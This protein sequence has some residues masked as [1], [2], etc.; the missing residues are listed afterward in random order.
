MSEPLVL[1]CDL[2]GTKMLAGLFTHQGDLLAAEKYLIGDRAGPADVLDDLDGAL[3][4]MLRTA[5]RQRAAVTALGFG[6][7]GVLDLEAGT[8]VMNHNLGW[9]DVPLGRLALQRL[10]LPVALEM[11]ANAAALGEFWRGAGRGLQNFAFVIVGTG[12]GAGLILDGRIVHGAHSA[13]GEVGHTVIL[14]GGPLCG[15]GKHG[16][17]EALASGLAL[18]RRA[19]AAVKLGRATVLSQHAPGISGQHVADAARAGDAVAREIMAEAA[20]YLGVGLA[21][22]ITLLDPQS[23]IIGG[24]VGAGAFDLLQAPLNQSIQQH[25]NYWAARDIPIQPSTLGEHAGLYGAARAAL[26]IVS[27]PSIDEVKK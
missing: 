15:C 14:P 19:E 7:T 26:N 25:L 17:L 24:G 21:N 20:F 13:A 22:I 2:G 12:I 6:S 16:C 10:G 23:I 1:A 8:V 27:H 3:E 11:D 18:S 4:R 9:R 5:G